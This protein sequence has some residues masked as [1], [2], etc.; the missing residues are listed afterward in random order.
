MLVDGLEREYRLHLPPDYD[1]NTASSL[2]LVFH[3][4]GRNAHNM[5]SVTWMSHHANKNGYIAVYPQS[6]SFVD[7]TEGTVYTWNDLSCNA[8]P[9]PEGPTCSPDAY[10]V[11][12]PPECGEPTDCNWCTCYDDLAFVEQL[13]DELEDTL[14]IDLNRVY[15]TGLGHGAMFAYRLGCDMADRYAAIAPVAGMPA[16]GF[17]C[18]PGGSA[19]TSIM[20]LH[21]NRSGKYPADGSESDHGWF[22]VPVDDVID[23]WASPASQGCDDIE[24]PYPTSKDGTEGLRCAQRANCA[25][26]AEV[27]SC[28]WVGNH[29]SA[30]GVAIH[31]GNDVIWE[32]F[33]KNSKQR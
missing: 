29:S 19:S 10:W 9:G 8:S 5:E 31:F 1:Q 12:F 27:V 21:P 16:K 28:Y 30:E 22:Y 14:C 6:T 25:T 18:A 32:F 24:T 7:P 26:G 2:V 15:A 17:S 20:H 4:Y 3:Q 13:L 33:D 11:P 23:A